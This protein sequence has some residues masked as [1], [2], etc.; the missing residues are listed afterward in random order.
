MPRNGS[1]TSFRRARRAG[2]VDV[3]A[4]A[5]A[6]EVTTETIRRDL[7]VLERAGVSTPLAEAAG[8]NRD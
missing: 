6:L 1:R 2:R 4:L 7:T 5:E 8:D 3:V